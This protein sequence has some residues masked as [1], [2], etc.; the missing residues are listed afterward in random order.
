MLL[1]GGRECFPPKIWKKT[2]MLIST[3]FIQTCTGG[4]TQYNKLKQKK[5][6]K[7]EKRLK[8]ILTQY[9]IP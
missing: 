5:R 9:S 7:K 8:G 4:S 1:N 2:G 6:K 3:T